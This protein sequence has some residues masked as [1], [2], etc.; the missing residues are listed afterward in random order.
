[1]WDVERDDHMDSTTA[2]IVVLLVALPILAV[3]VRAVWM[4]AQGV[5]EGYRRPASSRPDNRRAAA[6]GAV[7]PPA[8]ELDRAPAAR[9]ASTPQSSSSVAAQGVKNIFLSYRRADTTDVAGRIYDRLVSSFGQA[10]VFKDVDAIPL[11]V[12]FRVHLEQ[13]VEK[14]DVLLAIIGPKWLDIEEGDTKPR[15]EDPRDYVRIEIAAALQRGIPVIPVLVSGAAMP[16]EKHLPEAL[17]ALAYRHAAQVRPDPDFHNDM[18]RLIQGIQKLRSHM[19]SMPAKR[20]A[21]ER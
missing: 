14:A 4:F 6:G 15:L 20:T 19:S 18:G 10:S 1:M 2:I 7:V 3:V 13:A 8:N 16:A 12:D 11:G 21:T 17:S 9:Q 5:R